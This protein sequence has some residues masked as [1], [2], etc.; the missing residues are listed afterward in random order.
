VSVTGARTGPRVFL[1]QEQVE[2]LWREFAGTGARQQR[3]ALGMELDDGDV[4]HVYTTP[5]RAHFAGVPCSA[6]VDLRS[7]SLPDGADGIPDLGPRNGARV[8]VLL[9]LVDDRVH[10]RAFVERDSGWVEGTTAIVPVRSALYVRSSGLLETDALARKSAA[11]V[12]LGS[13]GSAIAVALAQA[14]IGRLVLVDRDRLE[15]GN[16]SRHACGIGDLGRLKTRAVRDL[17]LGK[18]PTMDVAMHDLDIVEE[19]DALRSALDGVDLVIAATDGDISRFL[20][21]QVTLDL[22][23]TTVFGRVLTRATGGDVLRVRPR[24]GPCLACVYTRQFLEQRP[25]EYSRES[26]AREDAEAYTSESDINAKI[27]VGLASDIAPVSNLITKIALVE[28]S[29]D[30]AG[31]L[32]ALD[33]DLR[34]D[35][36]IWANRREGTYADWPAMEFSFGTPSILRWYGANVP[37]R[38]GCGAC[39]LAPAYEPGFFSPETAGSVS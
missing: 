7:T 25:R 13:G 26:E 1:H 18:N 23:L 3:R 39:G 37:R 24:Q 14:G 35:F 20:I 22:D 27:Q 4:Y 16:V 12:G 15:V 17:A 10:G 33:A 11:I 5:P 6:V 31:G 8:V 34:A 21:N 9:S 30:T 19:P 38:P 32:E 36:Y 28:L 2:E 29:R